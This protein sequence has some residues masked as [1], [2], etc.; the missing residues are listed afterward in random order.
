MTHYLV[1]LPPGV[2][3]VL[4]VVPPIALALAA[5]RAVRRRVPHELLE[6][7]SGSTGAVYS[8]VGVVYAVILGFVV[9]VVW[10]QFGDASAVMQDEVSDLGV[11]LRDAQ[12]FPP[13]VRA[14]LTER[15]VGYARTV[16]DEEWATMAAGRRSPAALAAYERVWD[17]YYAYEPATPQ[18]AAF[19]DESLAV[20][21]DLS[22]SR[23]ERILAARSSVPAL[24][25]AMLLLGGVLVVGFTLFLSVRDPVL[26]A[27][28][29]AAVALVVSV[30]L[31]LVLTLDHPFAGTL[32]I[33]PYAFEDLV[34]MWTPD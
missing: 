21:T 23:R 20:L 27:A 32:R 5:L 6:A 34:A 11:L 1:S 8:M 14:D 17:A 19:R 4:V 29:V 31:F 10:Q 7:D 24:L 28:C 9:V 12:A 30:A 15:I 25:W 3:A 2:L 18:A 22:R 16:V 33:E 13:P 26:H